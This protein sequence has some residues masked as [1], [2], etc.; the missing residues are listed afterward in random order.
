MW[1]KVSECSLSSS[2]EHVFRTGVYECMPCSR[3]ELLIYLALY[4]LIA[5]VAAVLLAWLETPGRCFHDVTMPGMISPR[6]K[7]GPNLSGRSFAAWGFP[8]QS[9]GRGTSAI[10]P[11]RPRLLPRGMIR[12]LRTEALICDE[13]QDGV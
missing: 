12:G 6:P 1:R 11:L 4:F 2:L 7:L 3:A 10:L 13:A 9:R 8:G 5:R